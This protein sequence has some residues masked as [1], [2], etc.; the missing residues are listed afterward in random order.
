[1][2]DMKFGV[3][4]LTGQ[5]ESHAWIEHDSTVLLDEHRLAEVFTVMDIAALLVS[6]IPDFDQVDARYRRDFRAQ[7]ARAGRALRHLIH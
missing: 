6:K 3:R 4:T 7:S 1:M 5:F 2:A